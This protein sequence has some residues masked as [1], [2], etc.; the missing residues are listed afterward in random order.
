MKR[1]DNFYSGIK[2]RNDSPPTKKTLESEYDDVL[3]KSIRGLLLSIVVA[4]FAA[5]SKISNFINTGNN[6]NDRLLLL[7][8]GVIS[9]PILWRTYQSIKLAKIDYST[10]EKSKF[11]EIT[12]FAVQ[13]ILA[14]P[15]LLSFFYDN[16]IMFMY[17]IYTSI[18]FI[19]TI[20]FWELF[21]VRFEKQKERLDYICEKKIQ[22]FNAITFSILTLLFI[23]IIV[24]KSLAVDAAWAY[25]LLASCICVLLFLNILHSRDLTYLPKIILCN[26]KEEQEKKE[27]DNSYVCK[28]LKIGRMNKK[29]ADQIVNTIIK[30]FKYVFEYIFDTSDE[31]TLKPAIRSLITSAF[32]FGFLGYMNFYSIKQSD[33]DTEVGLIKIDTLHKCLIYRFL[34]FITLPI[35]IIS[36][37]GIRKLLPIYKRSKEIIASQPKIQKKTEFELTYFV[38]YEEFRNKKYGTCAMNLLVNALFHSKTNNINCSKLILLVREKNKNAQYLFEKN[39]G[40]KEYQHGPSKIIEEQGK[41]VFFQYNKDNN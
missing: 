36:K 30:E 15:F 7:L 39:I 19:A 8:F 2:K 26:E 9:V 22:R 32:G 23:A 12:F 35:V 13:F 21:L 28:K 11:D 16:N 20:N 37:F 38:I 41:G 17:A 34:E 29:D 40:F 4:F 18:S 1:E 3:K 25:I 14:V 31:T 5:Y 27:K 10:I 6:Q 33:S 24:I